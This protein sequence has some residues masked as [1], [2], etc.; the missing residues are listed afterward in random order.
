MEVKDPFKDLVFD[1][2][3]AGY[4]EFRRK[5]I[6]S[7]AS[8]EDRQQHL[9]GPRLVNRLSGEAWRCTEHL[10]ISAIRSQEGWLEVL[11][12]LDKHY[13]YLPET[14]LHESIDEFL[15]MLKKRH[16][17]GATAFASRFKTQLN[18]LETL[19][20]QERS[21]HSK[22][23]K[24]TSTAQAAA[25]AQ[26]SSSSLEDSDAP[27]VPS[28]PPATTEQAE[29]EDQ[30]DAA[31]AE[32]SENVAAERSPTGPA[33]SMEGSARAP[34][35]GASSRGSK[36]H[37][38]SGTWKEDQAKAQREMQRLLGTL[39]Q[40][41]RRPKSI[42]PQSVL[43]HL[44][45]R[46]YGLNREQRALVI[47]S[48][49]GSSRFADIERI[50]RASDFEENRPD[51]RKPRM[52]DRRTSGRP[53]REAYNVQPAEEP[54][55][56][57]LDMATS[58]SDDAE[59]LEA[60][61]LESGDSAAE[62]E[63][64][65]EVQK[66]AKKDFKKSFKSYKESKRRVKEIKKSRQ[67]YM[68]V[69]ALPAG[70]DG[71]ANVSTSQ[72]P[73]QKSFQYERKNM[74]KDSYRRKPQGS[75][76]PKS[77]S[78]RKEEANM[79]E[80]SIV[81]HFNYA[82]FEG[83]NED[84]LLA[85]IPSGHAVID[86]GCTTSVVGS[87]T[88]RKYAAHFQ[89]QGFP[90]PQPVDLPAVELRGFGGEV[91]E[92][93]KGLRW[94]VR[95]GDLQGSVT[96]YVVDGNTPF[97]LSRKVLEAMQATLDLGKRT[98]TSRVHGM[99]EVPLKQSSNGHFLLQLC[100]ES[101]EYETEYAVEHNQSASGDDQ[102]E[103]EPNEN[104]Q[105]NDELEVPQ[106]PSG[107]VQDSADKRSP[108]QLR[109][110]FQHIVKNTRTGIV[111]LENHQKDLET[112][113][114]NVETPIVEAR[115]A[116]RPKKERIPSD[117]GTETYQVGIVSLS[118][119]GE[120]IVHPWITR[121]PGMTRHSVSAMHVAVFAFRRASETEVTY[122]PNVQSPTEVEKQCFCCNEE[123]I[124]LEEN[125]NQGVALETLYEET[126]WINPQENAIPINPQ[127]RDSLI[128]N[129][130]SIRKTNCRMTLTRL[131]SER[132]IVMQELREWLGDQACS[133]D[134]KVGLIEVFTGKA[135]L[136]RYYTR[137]TG[138]E[139]I[140]I[141]L[142][143]GHDLNRLHDRRMLLMLIA[144]CRPDHVWLSFPCGPW[145][146]W[147]RLNIS[148]SPKMKEDIENQRKLARRHLRAVTESWYLQTWLGGHAH[149]ENPWSSEAWNELHLGQVWHVRIDQC[150][151]GLRSPKSGIPVYKPTRIV[152]TQETLMKDL[153]NCRC[154][155]NHSHEHL[156]GSYKGKNLTSWAE[157]YPN[158]MCR[159][160]AASLS[161]FTQTN[162]HD[163]TVEEVLAEDID[164]SKEDLDAMFPEDDNPNAE[165]DNPIAPRRY[166]DPLNPKGLQLDALVRK[167]HVNTGHS[168]TEQMLRLANRCK[169]S[170]DLKDRIKAFKC[171]VCQNLAAPASHRKSTIPHAEHPNQIV[172]VDFVFVDLKRPNNR[173]VVEE[174]HYKVITCVDLATGFAQ[175]S[176]I[177]KGPYGF[178]KAFH[179]TWTRPYGA[180]TIV[181]MDPDHSNISVDFQTYLAEHQIQLLHCAAQAHHQLGQV[182]IANRV[183]RNM[184][185][186]VWQS[187]TRP[188]EEVIECCASIRNDQLKRCGF[189]PSQWFL[190]REPRHAGDLADLDEQHNIASQSQV[191]TIP[192]FAD[193]VMLREQAKI[194]FQEEH[195]KDAWR[196][197][198]ASKSRPMRGPYTQ[199][200]LVYM[201][202][203]RGKGL[204]S[205]RHGTW[206]GPA[207][208][209][210]TESSTGSKIPRIVWCSYNGFLYR[211]SPEGLRP[212]SEDEA[213]FRK[214]AQDLAVSKL[215]DELESADKS[216]SAGFGNYQD[217]SQEVPEDGDFELTEDIEKEPD[218]EAGDIANSEGEPR[219]IRRRF[220]KPRDY[221]E[222]KAR[223]EQPVLGS[224]HVGPTPQVIRA[225]PDNIE[226]P[227]TEDQESKRRRIEIDLDPDVRTY[228]PA[229]EQPSTSVEPLEGDPIE[230]PM[231]HLDEEMVQPAP[232]QPPEDTDMHAETS[233][234]DGIDVPIPVDDEELAVEG[235]N[236]PKGKR[237]HDIFEVSIDVHPQ[238]IT[239]DPLCLWGVIEDCFNVSVPKAKQRRVEVSLRKL[240]QE[241][242][243]RFEVAMQKEW[244]SWIE[245]KVISL[246]KARGIPYERII[247]ARWVLTWKKSSDPDIKEKTPKARLVLVGWQDPEL[248]K[249][250]T[251]SP[252]LR[253]ESKSIVLSICASKRWKLWGADIKT[254]FLSGDAQC[255]D[256]FFRPPAEIK[257]WM[258]LSEEDLF[259]LEKAAYGL[260]EAPR[261]WYLRLTREL[262]ETGLVQSQLDPCLFVLREKGKLEGVCG[263]HVDDLLG[264]GTS[265]MDTVLAN[266]KKKLPFGDFRTHTIRYTGVEVRQ[267]PHRFN[268]EVGQEAYIEALEPVVTKHLGKAD[269]KLEDPSILRTC[270]G[271]LAW[272]ANST[273]P[274]QSFL[275]SYLQGVQDKG[276]VSHIHLYNKAIREMKAHKVCLQFPSHVKVEDW[277]IVCFADAGWCTRE[278]G[279]SQGGYVLALSNSDFFE[280]K[281]APCWI[282]DW[283]SKK[284]R[285]VVRSSVAA[286]TLSNQNGLDS[287]EM[288]QALIA[289]TVHG[290]KPRDF[291]KTKPSDV[292]ALVTDSKGFYDAVT[293]SC[294]SS[295]LSAERRL[296]IDY[297]IAKET[298][299][300]Q[301]I[302]VFWANNLLMV[303]D[304][305]TKLRGDTKPLYSLIENGTF[306]LKIC[307]ESGKKEKARENSSG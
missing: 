220:Y 151:V 93:T 182:E 246:C 83:C 234:T 290:L 199:G 287:V 194:A 256:I 62:L 124:E 54:S 279:D 243:D 300:N 283:S 12:T 215:P 153:V 197:A 49:G 211:C 39:E 208:V 55:S 46:K 152:S 119:Q 299:Q 178:A 295:A 274:D 257:K 58:G 213:E 137:R 203:R 80:S 258:Q 181:Y 281:V 90:A 165:E 210:G 294:A 97:L 35:H 266:L 40:G 88:A 307:T 86:T 112:L 109:R 33:A 278:N 170:K 67:P 214:L 231:E 195:A 212:M 265:K 147:S 149:A 304:C 179:D 56:S 104:S 227:E 47:R 98:I 48:T 244:N 118:P 264:G 251:D 85:S 133:L 226:S 82:V 250:A 81:Q 238:D 9:A 99:H 108:C 305:L 145:G 131:H 176:I 237:V 20:S 22:K 276:S 23:K 236:L 154:D 224:L 64:L 285:R 43:G 280:H 136:S 263:I 260:A 193:S 8:L 162:K 188:P 282:I 69:V 19:I 254:A 201:Y 7:V 117:A 111:S 84:I 87:E 141:G 150:A 101:C 65:Y 249:V 106:D 159:L 1:G 253:K 187:S 30:T 5:V 116:Y 219:K 275:A 192:R 140:R 11:R 102:V 209:V 92:T 205:T 72:A 60:E 53:R 217:L 21:L 115:V 96:T 95:I 52:D 29:G 122:S 70:S 28:V 240:T 172:G 155:K 242:K 190:G 169:A 132:T 144:V 57:S 163:R 113:F 186:K 200:Q 51:D 223:G 59:V 297:A 42:F 173:G 94:T 25:P 171:D 235:S 296:Q 68:P 306:H 286:E 221:W 110:A 228:S 277:K 229:D 34:S 206:L 175:Q 89:R 160:I 4:R 78:S 259:R 74:S 156:E 293:R 14:E 289:E 302:L 271:Q 75:A 127:Q 76:K 18:R 44:F 2:R 138:L 262:K 142:D 298:C 79:T 66:K 17:E 191:R 230:L 261:Q 183:L 24:K 143:Y 216:L 267:D 105:T 218:K 273:R 301:C 232:P 225:T 41:H 177:Q 168:S 222:R 100:P 123:V 50:L 38:T 198:V 255:R 6:L 189:S 134:R 37:S 233:E 139:S 303:A 129:I 196:L 161:Q 164:D 166:H 71:V 269:T 252:T 103:D 121:P 148:R 292:A 184:A 91:K 63:E 27:S 272:V 241:D 26:E 3:P 126:D 245:N 248:G 185:Q 10:S 61:E 135:P 268:I 31:A 114:G 247:R 146:S 157:T 204:L 45:M 291:R 13:R 174:K 167:L 284:L 120:L 32:A 288:L 16:G 270:A 207:R 130:Q 158:K 239:E 77:N 125:S 15:F 202:R 128:K 180:P 107:A 36:R 73:V